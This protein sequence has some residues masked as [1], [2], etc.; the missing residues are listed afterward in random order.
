MTVFQ[1]QCLLGYLGYLP[2]KEQDGVEGAKTKSAMD[3]FRSD[4]GVE[5]DALGGA[6]TQAIAQTCTTISTD[7]ATDIKDGHTELARYLQSD[8]YYHIPKSLHVQLSNNFNS[9]E[10]RCGIGRTCTDCSD[11]IINPKLVAYLQQIREH[12]NAEVT[13]TSAYRCNSYNRSVSGATG[14]R[15]SRGD[16]ADIVV[17]G[18]TPITVAKYCESI[19]I[20]GIG[21]YESS[22][23]GFFV[24]IDT[25]DVKSFWYGQ[26]QAYRNTFAT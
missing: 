21:L 23:D 12:F 10:F 26:A 6:I 14:S 25:R 2:P 3:K 16:A 13:I 8:G 9:F 7:V 19:G 20:N 22:A 18:H 15:H 1:R 17:K 24:H 11:T 4:C 5:I